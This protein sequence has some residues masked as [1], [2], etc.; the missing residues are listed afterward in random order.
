MTQARSLNLTAA[1]VSD[2][3]VDM[4][5]LR[6]GE[7]EDLPELGRPGIPALLFA[8]DGATQPVTVGAERSELPAP[9]AA[10]TQGGE[11]LDHE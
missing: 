6:S 5:W 3:T 2:L 4:D 10:G 11:V 7:P 8:G 1:V 9:R